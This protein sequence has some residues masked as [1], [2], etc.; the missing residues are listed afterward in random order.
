[1]K[2]FDE[3]KA[4]AYRCKK[5]RS[6]AFKI[7]QNVFPT[8]SL[9]GPRWGAHDAPQ[10]PS[11]LGRGHPHTPLHSVPISGGESPKYFS[12]SAPGHRVS[13][14]LKSACIGQTAWRLL[15]SNSDI[16]PKST[17]LPHFFI[18]CIIQSSVY[19]LLR[20][21]SSYMFN[22]TYLDV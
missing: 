6:V 13:N 22:L 1:M 10:T 8:G 18:Y 20:V 19:A 9:P 7:R 16:L 15:K 2:Q 17:A 21:R 12:I 3:I 4:S 5:E 11:R 14:L